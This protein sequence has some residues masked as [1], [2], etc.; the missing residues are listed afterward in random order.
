MDDENNWIKFL[1]SMPSIRLGHRKILYDGGGLS[2][3]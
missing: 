1:Q 2:C 3:N